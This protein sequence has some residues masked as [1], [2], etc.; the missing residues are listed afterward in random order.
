MPRTHA[1]GG[2]HPYVGC[3]LTSVALVAERTQR[4]QHLLGI[5]H[6][7]V[8]GSLDLS[9][10]L[11][12]VDGLGGTLA[13]IAATVEFRTLATQPQ[14]VER[15]ALT[16]EGADGDLFRH[17]GIAAANAGEACRLRIRTELN[18]TLAGSTNLVD[19]MGD[20]RILDVGLIG[21][22]V[23]DQGIVLQG[24][25]HPLAQ[26]LLANDRSRGVVG[27]AEIDDIDRTTFG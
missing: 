25:V 4:V 3:I 13:D 23:E 20:L 6:V 27:I 21:G 15:D 19:R 11:W 17:D 2:T 9:L 12:R 1:V 8:D 24:V 14:L 10:A 7:V 18:G 16:L 5:L 26:F 22:I